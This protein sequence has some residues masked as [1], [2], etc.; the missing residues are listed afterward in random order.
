[1]D[2]GGKG[3]IRVKEVRRDDNPVRKLGPCENG[4]RC[5]GIRE[6]KG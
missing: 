5:N 4:C 3:F 6:C 1:M 2:K